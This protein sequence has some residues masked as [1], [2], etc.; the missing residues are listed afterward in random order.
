[1]AEAMSME[2]GSPID[3]AI[4]THAASGQSHIEDFILRLKEFKFEEHFDTKS[5]NHISL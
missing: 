1:M 2:M 5:N 4:S 3:F